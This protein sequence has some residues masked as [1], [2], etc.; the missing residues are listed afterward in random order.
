MYVHVCAVVLY[1]FVCLISAFAVI[2]SIDVHLTRVIKFTYLINISMLLDCR[3]GVQP[4][5][6]VRKIVTGKENDN[7]YTPMQIM[8]QPFTMSITSSLI[9]ILIHTWSIYNMTLING[10]R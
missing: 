10:H 9:L 7:N 2:D 4:R 8:T 1:A 6:I 3:G 5:V